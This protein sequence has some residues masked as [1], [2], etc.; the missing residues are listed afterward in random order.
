MFVVKVNVILK[1]MTESHLNSP[2]SK[3]AD[4]M[5]RYHYALYSHLRDWFNFR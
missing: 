1:D 2:D 5:A 3:Y 4:S